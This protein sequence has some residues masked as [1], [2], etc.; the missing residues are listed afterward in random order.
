MWQNCSPPWRST[1][2]RHLL[3]RGRLSAES[4]LL[5]VQGQVRATL[6]MVTTPSHRSAGTDPRA[7]HYLR[8]VTSPQAPK[9][10]PS[11]RTF[12]PLSLIGLLAGLAVYLGPGDGLLYL[13]AEVVAALMGVFLV[14][15]AI[16][17]WTRRGR[18]LAAPGPAPFQA[19]PRHVTVSKSTSDR[20]VGLLAIAG[21]AGVFIVCSIVQAIG[22]ASMFSMTYSQHG[23]LLDLLVNITFWPGWV[24]TALLLVGGIVALRAAD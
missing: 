9:L 23:W 10:L 7:S 1:L 21:A 3:T 17:R 14:N 18:S 13:A 6:P 11:S 12:H 8:D 5:H 24:C 20:R 2:E 22:G 15:V 4:G 19:D 16:T